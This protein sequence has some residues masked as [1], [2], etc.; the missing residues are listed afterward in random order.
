MGGFFVGA[1]QIIELPIENLIPYENN[2]RNNDKAVDAV[3]ASINSFGFKVPVVIDKDNVIVTGHTR[4]KA[5]Q[6][7]GIDK[8]PCIR[9]DDLSEEQIKA[10]RLADNKVSELATWDFGKL[11][12][13]LAEIHI[14]MEDF[15]FEI[16]EPEAD[17]GYY[18]DERERTINSVN[19]TDYDPSRVAGKYDMPIIKACQHVPEDLISFNYVL[20]TDAFDKGVHFYIDDYQFERI[21]N[22]P[23]TYMERLSEFDCCLTPDFSL[24]TDMPVAMQIWNIFR[25]RLIGQ[26]M[27]DYGIE[28]I[29]TLSWCRKNSFDFCFD[30]LEPGGVVSVSTIGV[31][32][33]ENATKLWIDGM[34]EAMKR[35]KPSHV[36][37]YGGDIGYDFGKTK[38]TY[39]ANHNA[40]R[41]KNGENR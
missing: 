7:L 10:F 37:I 31:K 12:E 26:I 24:Y 1:M 2:P 3:A 38:V 11:D 15:G 16:K 21:W 35:L 23:H 40:E 28:V 22:S 5:A 8:I 29:P 14:D 19:L 25:S 41:L 36:I 20:N 4:I 34:N 27:Q 39:I 32:E 13:E 33:D 30:G 9:A 17:E 18:G 6:K